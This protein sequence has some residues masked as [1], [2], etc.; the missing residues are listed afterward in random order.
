MSKP[1]IENTNEWLDCPSD[2]ENK[3]SFE[4]KFEE[5]AE[6]FAIKKFK[7]EKAK[8]ESVAAV[9]IQT[10]I[11]YQEKVIPPTGFDNYT[12]VIDELM[13]SEWVLPFGY[14]TE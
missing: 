3:S 7:W 6:T 5:D 11:L 1:L 14:P 12:T 8:Q 13:D 4:Y 2:E 10:P 9:D